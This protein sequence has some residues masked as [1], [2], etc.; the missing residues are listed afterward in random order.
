MDEM[1]LEVQKWLNETYT[2]RIGYTPIPEDG[3]TGNT[4][5]D[6]LI[7]GLQY[8]IGIAFPVPNFGPST[9]ER[10]PGLS[11]Q[12]SNEAP[13]NLNMILQGGFWCKGYNPG[14]FTGNF[15]E[16]TED[17]VREF[18]S[19]V[20]L[21]PTGYVDAKLMEAILNTDG[22]RQAGGYPPYIR[23]MQQLLNK[24][25]N[26]YFD[27]IPTNG[28]YERKTNKAIIYALQHEIGIGD[29]ANGNYGPSTEANTPTLTP[30]NENREQNRV[31]QF[32]LAANGYYQSS[33]Y[34]G[35]YGSA[36]ESAVREFQ[37]FMTLPVIGI[38]DMATIKQLLTSNGWTGRSA[39][40]C[41][42]S[43]IVDRPKA[44]TLVDHGYEIIGRYLT[45]TVGGTRSKA[46]THTELEI[47]EEYGIRV[48]P[49]YQDGGYYPEYFNHGRGYSDG[50]RAIEAADR[51]GFPHG[52]TIYFAVDFDAYDFQ[53]QDRILP[54]L[55]GVRQALDSTAGEAGISRYELGVY[56]PRNICIQAAGDSGVRATYSFVANMSTGFS[57]NLGYPMPTNWSFSQFYEYTIT[58]GPDSSTI[59][60]DKN[61]YSGRDTGVSSVNPP[62]EGDHLRDKLYDEMMDL[63]SSLPSFFI[64]PDVFGTTFAFNQEIPVFESLFYS[65]SLEAQI[66]Y[67]IGGEDAT[68][69][70]VSDGEIGYDLEDIINSEEFFGRLSASRR[71]E[72]E[73]QLSDLSATIGNGYIE[74]TA[75]MDGMQNVTKITAYKDDIRIDEQNKVSL[76]VSVIFE[77]ISGNTPSPEFG[78]YPQKLEFYYAAD[79]MD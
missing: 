77:V 76:A 38:A 5:V 21:N 62:S 29:I 70:T 65:I 20:G 13:T 27:Y 19:D 35:N 23:T 22:F 44:Q 14:G 1:V 59:G 36:V 24:D 2:G 33:L 55:R 18:E 68:Y 66:N 69:I 63:G 60:I 58:S 40:A 47:L 74:F 30:G 25:Y 8:E 15:F 32:A 75:Y 46:M 79:W 10:F 41:D 12:E 67:S 71:L 34:D 45:G 53:V 7:I 16:A 51:L 43:T 48:F 3:Q 78:G 52:T 54:Y 31:L 50:Y 73:E 4:T 6:A 42:A 11:K 39:S 57:G 37:E 17:K 61:D 64:D 49:I 72:Y 28:N 26:Q 9:K 56:G